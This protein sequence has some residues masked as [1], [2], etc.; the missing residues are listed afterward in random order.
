M[1]VQDNCAMLRFDRLC[2][3][4]IKNKCQHSLKIYLFD[5]SKSNGLL[6]FLV[7]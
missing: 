5:K 2:A 6:L 4:N 7:Y 3:D 1:I